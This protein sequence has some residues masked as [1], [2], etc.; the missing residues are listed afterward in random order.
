[1]TNKKTLIEKV[2]EWENRTIPFDETINLFQELIDTGMAW[3]LQG[4]YG[5]T[6]ER[7]INAG[8][9]TVKEGKAK[10]MYIEKEN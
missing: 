6:A 10:S 8:F 2:V 9:C 4:M 3:N 7:L 1:M 5:R